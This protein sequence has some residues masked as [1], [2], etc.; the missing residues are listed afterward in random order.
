MF[1]R[2][3]EGWGFAEGSLFFVSSA[4][5][6]ISVIPMFFVPEGGIRSG[7]A[8][9]PQETTLTR[10]EQPRRSIWP[11]V[12][13]LVGMT[14]VNFGRNAT[15]VINSQY[16]YLDTGFAVSSATLS[17]IINM[18][19]VSVVIVGFVIGKWGRNA[20]G[21]ILLI[22]GT[23][24]AMAGL[25]L[26]NLSRHLGWIY[27]AGLFGGASEV[28]VFASSYAIASALIP[29]EKRATLFGLFNATFFLSW[30][31]SATL[32]AGPL[33]DSLIL[34]GHSQLF[35]YRASYLVALGIAAIGLLMLVIQSRSRAYRQRLS[36][37]V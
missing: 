17:T 14:F 1:G 29:P 37:G 28:L 33:V 31:A 10:P 24:S 3:Y 34:A 4:V 19:S 16:L 5:M 2:G 7:Q 13:F 32:I 9:K 20:R 27:V 6:V 12:L 36:A 25:L 15:S 18:F 11:F 23:V 22:L 30:G 8:L 35:A 21:D 26:Y